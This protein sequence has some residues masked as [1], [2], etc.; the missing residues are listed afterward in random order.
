MLDRGFIDILHDK[1]WQSA[2]LFLLMTFPVAAQQ[3]ALPPE[4]LRVENRVNPIRMDIT[5][6]RLSW[7]LNGA[8]A[9]EYAYQVRAASSNTLLDQGVAD[10]WDSG[11]VVSKA[12]SGIAYGGVA[13]E[14]RTRVFWQVRV[15]TDVNSVSPWSATATWEMGLLNPSDWSAQWIANA[16]WAYGEPLPIFARQFPVA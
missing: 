9:I 15:W 11:M 3:G 8:G 4:R 7:I 10:L 14:S 5:S 12:S 1:G 2:G 16:N 6:P 13:I